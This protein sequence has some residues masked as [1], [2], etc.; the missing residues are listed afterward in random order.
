MAAIGPTR[1]SHPGLPLDI[2]KGVPAPLAYD[3]SRT[4]PNERSIPQIRRT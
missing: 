2:K 4:V 1:S 3:E